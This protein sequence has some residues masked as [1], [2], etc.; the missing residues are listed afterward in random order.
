MRSVNS[1][2]GKYYGIFCGYTGVL[3]FDS[4]VRISAT[5][6]FDA[7]EFLPVYSKFDTKTCKFDIQT[8]HHNVTDSL[9]AVKSRAE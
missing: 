4:L 7:N 8:T 6:R 2:Q 9:L 5:H 1:V 3:Y